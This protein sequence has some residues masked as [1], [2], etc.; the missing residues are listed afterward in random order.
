MSLTFFIPKSLT[1]H[2]TCHYRIMPDKIV[3]WYPC[4]HTTWIPRWNDVETVHV[5]SRWNPRGV[6]VGIFSVQCQVLST[7]FQKTNEIQVSRF[8]A[9]ELR[10]LKVLRIHRHRLLIS[11]WIHETNVYN[12]II[13]MKL[14]QIVKLFSSLF[15]FFLYIVFTLWFQCLRCGSNH[16]II[17]IQLHLCQFWD[18]YFSQFLN[19]RF[20]R[21]A[22]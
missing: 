12:V 20:V 6:F 18:A 7:V 9:S 11:F 5:V 14:G 3:E 2:L 15:V 17:W 13:D 19:L 10:V 21:F 4:K 22:D 1:S 8:P 16:L